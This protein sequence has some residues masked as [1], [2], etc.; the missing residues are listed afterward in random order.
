M[1]PTCELFRQRGRLPMCWFTRAGPLQTPSQCRQRTKSGC[2]LTAA[3]GSCWS[4]VIASGRPSVY[5]NLQREIP[6]LGAQGVG[7]IAVAVAGPL[8][9]AYGLRPT[10]LTVGAPSTSAQSSPTCAAIPVAVS[11]AAGLQ[12][13]GEF[14]AEGGAQPARLLRL[15]DR[16]EDAALMGE[17][18]AQEL[19]G[20]HRFV[21]QALRQGERWPR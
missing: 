14:A 10:L 2:C 18:E 9:A 12:T 8:L 19:A 17:I 4:A 1:P 21:R 3:A 20:E 5:G 11:P 6:H 7:P 15:G 13:P 16:I